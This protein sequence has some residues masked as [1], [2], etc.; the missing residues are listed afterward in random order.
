LEHSLRIKVSHYPRK[1]KKYK[2]HLYQNAIK[3]SIHLKQ[4]VKAARNSPKTIII[5]PITDNPSTWHASGK[6]T[7]SHIKAL[8]S[9]QLGEE[10][11]VATGFVKSMRRCK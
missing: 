4:L 5:R 3:T 11:H 9:K 10:R 6:K 2:P 1:A 8:D 7:R